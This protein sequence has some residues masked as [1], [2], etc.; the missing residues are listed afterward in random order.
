MT[1]EQYGWN[2]TWMNKWNELHQSLENKTFV[3][4]RIVGDF[5]SKY[6]VMTE[7]GET[8]GSWQAGSDIP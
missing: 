6:R 4:G 5:G 7:T 8:W 3:P 2:E 1:I